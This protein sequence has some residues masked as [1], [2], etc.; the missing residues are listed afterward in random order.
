MG[1]HLHGYSLLEGQ[2]CASSKEEPSPLQSREAAKD[3]ILNFHRHNHPESQKKGEISR[4]KQTILRHNI[5]HTFY[6]SHPLPLAAS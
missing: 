4:Q 6:D 5:Q 1:Q 2:F 3:R